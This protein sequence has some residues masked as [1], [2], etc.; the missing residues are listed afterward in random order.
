MKK[1]RSFQ[2]SIKLFPV[3]LLSFSWKNRKAEITLWIFRINKNHESISSN[4]HPTLSLKKTT[5]YIYLF[6]TT[7]QRSNFFPIVS[8][9]FFFEKEA[10]HT[11]ENRSEN[12]SKLQT[13]L[14]KPLPPV[15]SLFSSEKESKKEKK[16]KKQQK[17]VQ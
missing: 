1:H 10:E 4:F 3:F 8:L 9:L 7:N 14:F 12:R 13:I 6:K 2:E 16:K 11:I 17:E 15:L 5:S